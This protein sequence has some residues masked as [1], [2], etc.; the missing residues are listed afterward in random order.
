VELKDYIV[1]KNKFPGNKTIFKS[2]GIGL[3]D[4]AAGYVVLK[5]MGLIN[6]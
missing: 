5:N 3:E 6:F 1:N 2:M 4:V